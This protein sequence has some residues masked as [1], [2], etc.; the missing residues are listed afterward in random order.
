MSSL[1]YMH[2]Y[3]ADF[4]P[5]VVNLLGMIPYTPNPIFVIK[6]DKFGE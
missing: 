1:K 3:L 2:G 6:S 5:N 4:E